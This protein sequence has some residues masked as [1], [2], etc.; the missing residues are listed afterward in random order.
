MKKLGIIVDSFCGLSQAEVEKHNFGFLPLQFSINDKQY[1]DNGHQVS[2]KELVDLIA[3][4]K[5]IHTSLPSIENIE[6]LLEEMANK[7]ENVLVFL[8]SSSLSS[9][10]Q[11]VSIIAKKYNDKFIMIDNHFFAD[12]VI[13]LGNFLIKKRDQGHTLEKIIEIAKYV[14]DNSINYLVIKDLT[15]LIRGGRIKGLKKYILSTFG[16]IV[17]LKVNQNGISFSGVKKTIKGSFK[18]VSEKLIN[19]IKGQENIENYNFKFMNSNNKE[20][21]LVAKNIVAQYNKTID[22]N[23]QASATIMIHTGIECSSLGI[24]PDLEKLKI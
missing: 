14:S 12:Q 1:L 21:A 24:W 9:T 18:K 4:N 23:C 7:Y 5:D 17:I 2:K 11:T 13:E 22:E 6:N 19:F 10:F 3:N 20:M 15:N 16:L 8:T